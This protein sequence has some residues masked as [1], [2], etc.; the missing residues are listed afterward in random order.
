MPDSQTH[1]RQ[2]F[3]L[4]QSQPAPPPSVRLGWPGSVCSRPLA[5][6]TSSPRLCSQRGPSSAALLRLPSPVNYQR[7]AASVS[8]SPRPA[9]AVSSGLPPLK[10]AITSRPVSRPTNGL[11]LSNSESDT[12]KE[13]TDSLGVLP[14]ASTT[15]SAFIPTACTASASACTAGRS[16]PRFPVANVTEEFQFRPADGSAVSVRRA[17]DETPRFNLSDGFSFEEDSADG[18]AGPL[19]ASER[20]DAPSPVPADGRLQHPLGPLL[21]D[22]H[23]A[24]PPSASRPERSPHSPHQL[25]FSPASAGRWRHTQ[26]AGSSPRLW[27][28]PIGG[29]GHSDGG[30]GWPGRDGTEFR[31]SSPV[32]SGLLTDGR[33]PDSSVGR[34]GTR[35]AAGAAAGDSRQPV[36]GGLSLN[37]TGTVRCSRP[38]ER[39]HFDLLSF[40][41]DS[42]DRAT[43]DGSRTGGSVGGAEG[44]RSGLGAPP[45]RLRHRA[46][47]GDGAAAVADR[48]RAGTDD[49]DRQLGAATDGSG[50]YLGH[51]ERSDTTGPPPERNTNRDWDRPNFPGSN[52]Y[53]ADH[54]DARDYRADHSDPSDYRADHSDP[55]DYRSGRSDQPTRVDHGSG[56]RGELDQR[57][58]SEQHR[59]T[60]SEQDRRGSSGRDRYEMFDSVGHT[61]R[62]CPSREHHHWDCE[63][64]EEKTGRQ[65]QFSDADQTRYRGTYRA[66]DRSGVWDPTGSP[67]LSERPGYSYRPGQ[68]DI[69]DTFLPRNSR[70]PPEP[71]PWD[72]SDFRLSRRPDRRPDSISRRRLD[73]R[74]QSLHRPVARR[75]EDAARSFLPPEDPPEE[76]PEDPPGR[77]DGSGFS[78]RAISPS[79]D[80]A[81][82]PSSDP[83]SRHPSSSASPPPS[84][85]AN[86]RRLS[87]AASSSQA[88]SQ[89]QRRSGTA[90]PGPA[91]APPPPRSAGAGG[92]W[93]PEGVGPAAG[94]RPVLEVPARYRSVFQQ[95]PYFNVV[96]STVMDDALYSGRSARGRGGG[97]EGEGEAMSHGGGGLEYA[98][99]GVRNILVVCEHV[100][101]YDML[102]E[103]VCHRS[104]FV[105]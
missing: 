67:E 53:R 75:R 30:A 61:D 97:D 39:P 102:Y 81:I 96:Q 57:M 4:S 48:Y 21:T 56:L 37:P 93:R 14:A 5:R 86:R 58:L 3:D 87:Q 99:V 49:W 63:D 70:Q 34:S 8:P 18:A 105:K 55:S 104:Y 25:P 72:S 95:F 32:D 92:V 22:S 84:P 65:R 60:A 62:L 101:M 1:L 68:S 69:R 82:S 2:L 26:V 89:R 80:R 71:D 77:W 59:R 11:C 40:A 83:T 79:S 23:T 50:H 19:S 46:D 78:V 15:A 36:S 38:A 98:V 51:R 43:D 10:G 20:R 103:Y 16:P 45:D 28:P 9:A 91:T 29:D 74:S 64:D 94:L 76:P 54:C 35:A 88:P 6:P 73:S 13:R 12:V 31:L 7:P 42:P 66:E 100:S 44:R 24:P 17:E 27:R 47:G 85:P 41:G 33:V 52:D 90:Y